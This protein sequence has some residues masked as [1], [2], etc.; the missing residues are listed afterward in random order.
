[1]ADTNSQV[2]VNCP[3]CGAPLR[4]GPGGASLTCEYC[5]SLYFPEKNEDGV[6]VLGES[7]GEAC[8]VCA[9]PLMDASLEQTPIRYCTRCRGMLIPMDSLAGLIDA[10][11]SGPARSSS[12]HPAG[13]EELERRLACPHCHE[14]MESYFYAGPGHV[15][16][17]GCERCLLNWLDAGELEQIAHA[18]DPLRDALVE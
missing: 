9:V 3:A 15:V 8:P 18:P 13:A 6:Q 5:R 7:S 2:W 11:R 17:A 10:M 16:I 14:A 4:L 12:A 1:M